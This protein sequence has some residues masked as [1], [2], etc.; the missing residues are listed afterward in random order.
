MVQPVVYC[1]NLST[2][3]LSTKH[4]EPSLFLVKEKVLQGK[5]LIAHVPTN[6]QLADLLTKVVSKGKFLWPWLSE[7]RSCM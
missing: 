2:M 5:L 1:D 7:A 3:M 4:M 6:E